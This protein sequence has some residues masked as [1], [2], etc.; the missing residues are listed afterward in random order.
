MTAKSTINR[1]PV[2]MLN[3]VFVWTSRPDDTSDSD[4]PQYLC[5][6]NSRSLPGQWISITLVCKHWRDV[7]L[8]ATELWRSVDAFNIVE[9]VELMFAR[10]GTKSVDIGLHSETVIL[11]AL[12][13]LATHAGRVR[14]LSLCWGHPEPLS[15]V[16]FAMSTRVLAEIS[17]MEFP[18]LE[19]LRYNA[20]G[21]DTPVMDGAP[22]PDSYIWE[23]MS[24]TRLP[25]LQELY[26]GQSHFPWN[27]A[28]YRQLRVLHLAEI[29]LVSDASPGMLDLDGFMALIGGCQ[30]LEELTLL[31]SLYLNFPPDIHLSDD[32]LDPVRTVDLPNLR[33]VYIEGSKFWVQPSEVYQVLGHMRLSPLVDIAILLAYDEESVHSNPLLH[34][35]PRSAANLPILHT[36]TFLTIRTILGRYASYIAESSRTESGMLEVTLQNGENERERE[37]HWTYD[38][39]EGL[40]DI[41]TIFAEARVRILTIIGQELEAYSLTTALRLLESLNNIEVKCRDLPSWHTLLQV[42]SSPAPGGGVVA[43]RLRVL[44]VWPP[45]WYEDLLQDIETCLNWRSQNGQELQRVIVNA[46]GRP[47]GDEDVEMQ[48]NYRIGYLRVLVTQSVV[49]QDLEEPWWEQSD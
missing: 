37:E 44:N 43:P 19:S 16:D 33:T 29:A 47:S 20:A 39:D 11:E 8:G 32:E 42:L 38:F 31:Y 22:G 17:R 24:P 2:E 5:I 1:L 46:H 35:I 10:S 30:M 21:M 6:S 27:S 12:P 25:A 45:E 49:F 48:H 4:P 23:G 41:C 13:L 9:G 34:I 3:E 15:D 14:S 18:V 7:A 28:L 26:L 40:I 36:A